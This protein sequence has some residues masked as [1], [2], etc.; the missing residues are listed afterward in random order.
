[1]C[2]LV[3]LLVI[4]IAQAHG[5]S[6]LFDRGQFTRT[7]AALRADLDKQLEEITERENKVTEREMAFASIEAIESE[8]ARKIA[9][10]QAG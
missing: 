1:M 3:G 5:F 6:Q 7:S 4:H 10:I 8:K 2:I 9:E